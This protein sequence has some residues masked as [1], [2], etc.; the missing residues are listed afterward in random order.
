MN[1]GV[2][3]LLQNEDL[4]KNMT[5]QFVDWLDSFSEININSKLINTNS[6]IT[7]ANI[8]LI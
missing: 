2:C 1:Y 7:F 5:G 8:A 3:K 6:I 4:N